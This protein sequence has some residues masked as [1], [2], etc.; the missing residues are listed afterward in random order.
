M[1]LR[2]ILRIC[3]KVKRR[4]LFRRLRDPVLDR[5]YL[6]GVDDCMAALGEAER[7]QEE[8]NRIPPREA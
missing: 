3:E 8:R 4:F 1:T 6:L 2:E 5:M 7:A